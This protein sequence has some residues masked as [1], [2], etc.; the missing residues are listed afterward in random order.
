MEHSSLVATLCTVDEPH[1]MSLPNTMSI[2]N[3]D[4]IDF[5]EELFPF[6]L[7]TPVPQTIQGPPAADWERLQPVIRRLYIEEGRTLKD[8]MNIML[9]NYDHKAT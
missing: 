4:H 1:S 5:A 3:P 8:I 7:S 2:L 6:P 9:G